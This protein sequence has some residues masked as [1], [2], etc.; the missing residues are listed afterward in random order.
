MKP[1]ETIPKIKLKTLDGHA[2]FEPTKI[3]RFEADKNYVLLYQIEQ[4]KP[5]RFHYKFVDI[6]RL[7]VDNELILEEIS[8]TYFYTSRGISLSK[9]FSYLCSNH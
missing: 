5:E 1:H 3:V 6:E 8:F 4:P 7:I 9:L 2:S